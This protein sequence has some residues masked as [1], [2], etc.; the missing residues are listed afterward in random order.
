MTLSL[1]ERVW[2][3]RERKKEY[4]DNGAFIWL[5]SRSEIGR[6]DVCLVPGSQRVRTSER[7]RRGVVCVGSG[8]YVSVE[9]KLH[10]ASLE[11]AVGAHEQHRA[12]S[13]VERAR[14]MGHVVAKGI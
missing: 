3:E 9:T 11:V 14:V 2:A 13:L 10:E 5:L 7:E 6:P 4:K 1:T 12:V 8:T